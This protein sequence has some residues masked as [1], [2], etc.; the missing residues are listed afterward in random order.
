MLVSLVVALVPSLKALFITPP[1][2]SNIHIG[3][4]PDGLPPLNIILDTATFIG[5]GCVPLGL[6][7]LGSALARL[8]VSQ[9]ISRAPIGAITAF[10]VLKVRENM[11]SSMLSAV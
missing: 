1:A 10:S 5:N 2:G 9:P 4:A 8:E 7:C 6:T 11:K 3:A